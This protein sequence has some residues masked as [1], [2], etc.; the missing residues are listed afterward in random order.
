MIAVFCTL[1]CSA[2]PAQESNS[3][4][5]KKAKEMTKAMQNA[6]L[7]LSELSEAF[8]CDY[9]GYDVNPTELADK[10]AYLVVI[11]VEHDTCDEMV[12]ALNNEGAKHDLAFVSEKELPAMRP[13]QKPERDLF[14]EIGA[15][16]RD[17]SLIHE[18][19]PQEDQ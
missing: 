6:Q 12:K 18:V 13:M 11:D 4:E 3:D 10:P 1:C 19:D 7:L 14:D 16:P 5:A 2:A 17:Y 9:V 8:G 15:P